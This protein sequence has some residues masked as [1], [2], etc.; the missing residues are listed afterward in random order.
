VGQNA[1]LAE[2]TQVGPGVWRVNPGDLQDQTA[3]AGAVRYRGF[4]GNPP[5]Q[6][7]TPNGRCTGGSGATCV[8][9]ENRHPAG[10]R[11]YRS[12]RGR[13]WPDIRS[14][15][16]VRAKRGGA[17]ATCAIKGHLF[18]LARKVPFRPRDFCRPLGIGR[19]KNSRGGTNNWSSCP[20]T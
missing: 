9:G 16:R 20:R 14:G 8:R 10:F 3:P 6:K 18:F 4:H 19:K 11:D 12:D 17:K 2:N 7:R 5:V 13:L 1:A 15:K